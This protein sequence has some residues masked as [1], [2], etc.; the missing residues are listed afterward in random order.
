MAAHAIAADQD[1]FPS[2]SER[3]EWRDDMFRRGEG[4]GVQ[5]IMGGEE[6]IPGSRPYLVALIGKY[7]CPGSLISPHA[8]MTVAHCVLYANEWS[9]PEYVEFHRHSF[10]NDTGVKRV[11]LNDRSQCGGD[12][13]YHPEYNELTFEN[14]VAIIF[15]PETIHDITPVKLN[16]DPNVP[17]SGAPLDVAGWGSTELT[18]PYRSP[19]PNAVTLDYVTNEACTKK[20]YRWPDWVVKDSMMCAIADGKSACYYDG[21]VSCPPLLFFSKTVTDF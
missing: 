7:F 18:F 10:L 3:I 11:Y 15:L 21:G 19:V 1:Y 8:V 6:I 12:I 9:S 13:V 17:V 5:S 4:Q 2:R 20:P 14:D 16:D